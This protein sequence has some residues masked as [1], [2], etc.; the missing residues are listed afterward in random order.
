MAEK[1]A[2][3]EFKDVTYVYGRPGERPALSGINLT[4]LKGEFVAVVGPNGSGKSTLA[5]HCNALLLPTE[6]N[7]I[8]GGLD[9][10]RPEHVWEV[11]RQVGMVFQNPDNQIV[12]SLVE[13]DVAF[14]AE[15]LG[16]PP[17][18]VRQ[19]VSEALELTGLSQYRKHA[20]HLL[21]G[22]QKQRLA[23]AGVLAM[24]PSCLVLD[25]PTAM[26]DPAGR[27]ELMET[28]TGLNRS[29]GVTVV[30]VTH[31]M[32]EAARAD[33]VVI[34]SGG[35]LAAAGSPAEIF[36]RSGLLEELGLEHTAAANI[37][38]GLRRRGFHAPEE[39]VIDE[40]LV[41]YVLEAGENKE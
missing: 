17:A 30:L 38:R 25:E 24:R 9:T 3:I 4:V 13:E 1:E 8:V 34:M 7:V 23:I 36:T 31:I 14:G 39:I 11:R 41:S 26:L 22:G 10:G 37:A 27:N 16:V 20:P 35:R 19:R 40:D 28:L 29:L 5:R 21:S 15:N 33:R 18:E 6:G 2:F 32:E 12:S